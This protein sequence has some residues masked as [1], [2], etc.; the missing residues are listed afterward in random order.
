M[1]PLY[2]ETQP[3]PLVPNRNAEAVFWAKEKKVALWL[4]Q[5]KE[6]T[7]GYYPKDC[8][9]RKKRIGNSL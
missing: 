1:L 5:A 7:A 6:A 3:L 9:L 2:A 8:A 4:C